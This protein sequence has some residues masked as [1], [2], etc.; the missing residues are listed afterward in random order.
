MKTT[1]N[2][3]KLLVETVD[4]LCEIKFFLEKAVVL[5]DEILTDYFGKTNFKTERGRLTAEYDS[6]IARVKSEVVCDYITQAADMTE[7]LLKQ[8]NDTLELPQI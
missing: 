5:A 3:I 6:N 8:A 7:K 1:E 4:S 2:S